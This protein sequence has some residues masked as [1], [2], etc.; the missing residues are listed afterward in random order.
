MLDQNVHFKNIL[1]QISKINVFVQ[2]WSTK[3]EIWAYYRYTDFEV[4]GVN[5]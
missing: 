4:P 5:Q 3:Y 2:K 1:Y